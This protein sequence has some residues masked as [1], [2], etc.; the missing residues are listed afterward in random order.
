MIVEAEETAEEGVEEVLSDSPID[1]LVGNLWQAMRQVDP[2][3]DP[4]PSDTWR[5]VMHRLA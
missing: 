2:V 4:A 5:K 1:V 3:L